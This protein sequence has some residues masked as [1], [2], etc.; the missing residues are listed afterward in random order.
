MCARCGCDIL[1]ILNKL[2]HLTFLK[3]AETYAIRILDIQL[4]LNKMS[5]TRNSD[6]HYVQDR[7]TGGCVLGYVGESEKRGRGER[8]EEYYTGRRKCIESET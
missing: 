1:D 8:G 4:S 5:E 3:V 7:R 2:Y 6:T